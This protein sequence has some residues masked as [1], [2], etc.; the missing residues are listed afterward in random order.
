[1]SNTRYTYSAGEPP[2]PVVILEVANPT[3]DVK[4]ELPALVDTGADVSVLPTAKCTFLNLV[5]SDLITVVGYDGTES[6]RAL[7]IA[8]VGIR[9]GEAS[10]ETVEVLLL[11]L[12]NA[13]VGRD[14]LNR[15][16]IVL[17]GPKL[18]LEL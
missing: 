7:H 11:D 9:G 10:K 13:I 5:R 18:V 8:S 17:D 16:R 4:I 1:M 14:I 3:T 12:P 15:H 2:Y 6:Q